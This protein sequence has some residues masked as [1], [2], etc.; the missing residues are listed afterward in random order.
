MQI[1]MKNFGTKEVRRGL[2]SRNNSADVLGL[3]F[4][5]VHQVLLNASNSASVVATR[6]FCFASYLCL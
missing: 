4:C 5:F 3:V 1:L 6:E 2:L